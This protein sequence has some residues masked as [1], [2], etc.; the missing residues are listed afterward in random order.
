M[1][2]FTYVDPHK[3]HL[4]DE[5]KKLANWQTYDVVKKE[6]GNLSINKSGELFYSLPFYTGQ[7]TPQ[8]LPFTG[9]MKICTDNGGD[10]NAHDG[11]WKLIRLSLTFKS[12]ILT[13]VKKLESEAV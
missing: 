9:D 12:G 8:F 10:Y 4:P 5:Y 6:M 2:L 13:R 1:G 11:S 7:P 3:S